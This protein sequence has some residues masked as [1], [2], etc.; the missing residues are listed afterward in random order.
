LGGGRGREV[1]KAGGSEVDADDDVTGLDEC[2]LSLPATSR[3]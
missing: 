3:T 2:M 1:V